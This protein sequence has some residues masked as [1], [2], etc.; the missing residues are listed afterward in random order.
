MEPRPFVCHVQVL[1]WASFAVVLRR[2][3]IANL[4]KILDAVDLP[5]KQAA[6]A[7]VWHRLV[8]RGNMLEPRRA[9][10]PE[11]DAFETTMQTLRVRMREEK[12]KRQ[13]KLVGRRALANT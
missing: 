8:W 11:P 13:G 2:D 7:N 6:L 12:R 10:L 3:Q 5:A 4:P 1:D 9:S